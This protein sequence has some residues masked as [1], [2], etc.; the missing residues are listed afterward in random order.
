MG[1]VAKVVMTVSRARAA[2]GF[3]VHTGWAAAIAV[4]GALDA[5][6]VIDRRKV[7]L[8]EALTFDSAAVYHVA[9]ELPFDQGRALVERTVR[10]THGRARAALDAIARELAEH[11]HEVV[12]VGLPAGGAALPGLADILRVHARVHAAEGA[13]Y[14]ESLGRAAVAS[15]PATTE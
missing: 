4:G 7:Q 1:G 8:A 9:A 5:P 3:S 13:L 10:A 6:L 14:R 11:G 2:V 15:E 12:A